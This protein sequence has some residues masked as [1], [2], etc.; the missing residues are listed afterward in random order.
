AP[1][2]PWSRS[3]GGVLPSLAKDDL[4]PTLLREAPAHG[5]RRE[6]DELTRMVAGDVDRKL[7]RELLELAFLRGLQPP[8]SDD[9]DRLERALDAVL[10]PQPEGR[11]V[12]LQRADRAQNQIVVDE[13][14]EEL[15]RALL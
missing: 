1:S 13:R 6:V 11:D 3:C 12:E 15:R 9:V 5:R 4:R 14:A 7:L 2:A 10:A 8:G